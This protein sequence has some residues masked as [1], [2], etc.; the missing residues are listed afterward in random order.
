MQSYECWFVPPGGLQYDQTVPHS[1]QMPQPCP[2]VALVACAHC[3]HEPPKIHK[4]HY[5]LQQIGLIIH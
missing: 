2:L 4:N 5:S 1:A 3:T